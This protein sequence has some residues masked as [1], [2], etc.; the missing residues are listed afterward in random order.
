ML[1]FEPIT[2]FGARAHGIQPD[3][4]PTPD[5]AEQLRAAL[6]RN[7]LLLFRG[8]TF[9]EEDHVRLVSAVG[10]VRSE[11]GQVVNY[12]NATP[13]RYIKTD[14]VAQ[15]RYL[16]HADYQMLPQGPLRVISLYGVKVDAANPTFFADMIAAERRL[17]DGLRAY[18]EARDNVQVPYHPRV[19]GDTKFRVSERPAS[20]PYFRVSSLRRHSASGERYVSVSEFFS[21]HFEGLSEPDSDAVFR[22]LAAIAYDPA[23]LYVHVWQEHDL[24]IFDNEA[25]QHARGRISGASA[26][27]L[28]RI[29]A[30]PVT[31]Q[32]LLADLGAFS[33]T[34]D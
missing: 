10:T 1:E 2:P 22:E 25:L 20:F 15:E 16:F 30:H 26:R 13:S 21:S 29:I 8:R 9:S 6:R 32:A 33:T 4:P 18:L 31:M 11:N 19:K 23:E 24:L 12:L 17:P 27:S 3:A 5:E 28:R 7:R 34:Y 14:A